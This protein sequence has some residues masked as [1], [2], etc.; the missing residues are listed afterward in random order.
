MINKTVVVFIIMINQCDELQG[1]SQKFTVSK[2]MS[3]LSTV[4]SS[5]K[6]IPNAEGWWPSLFK[7]VGLW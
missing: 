3:D 7:R 1:S 6:A 5:Y 4:V 2:N